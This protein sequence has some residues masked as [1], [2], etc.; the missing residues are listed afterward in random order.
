M[1]NVLN[2]TLDLA[3]VTLTFKILSRLYVKNCKVQ[4]VGRHI[5]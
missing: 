4:E 1:C 3:V 2:L 5:G